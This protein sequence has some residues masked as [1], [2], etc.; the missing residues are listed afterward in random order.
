MNVKKT[1]LAVLCMW[2]RM[3]D[4]GQQAVKDNT[5]GNGSD[6]AVNGGVIH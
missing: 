4:Q 1:I 6:N 5:Q 2:L 3:T